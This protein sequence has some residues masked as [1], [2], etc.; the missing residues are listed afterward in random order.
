M[1][2]EITTSILNGLFKRNRN[3][4]IQ[5]I[6]SFECKEVVI[7]FEKPKKKRSN[8]QNRY[9]WSVLIPITQ[10]AI[11]DTWGEVWSIEKTHS[12]L[13]ENFC[14]NEKV[15][16]ITGQIIKVPKSTTENTTTEME[17]YH[18]EIRDHLKEWFNVD[19]PLPNEDLTLNFN[20]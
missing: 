14:F 17:V 11:L 20:Q 2:I 6:K 19:A 7:T 12:Y 10:N 13:K 1:K 8:N 16:E 9:Y 4:V 18:T 15:N 5:A 3:T